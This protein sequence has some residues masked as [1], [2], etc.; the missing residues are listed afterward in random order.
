MRLFRLWTR[1]E[2]VTAIRDLEGA[3]ASGAQSISYTG[4]GT[5][6][7]VTSGDMSRTLMSLYDRLDQLDG[8]K[9]TPKVRH[10]RVNS[11]KG[12]GYHG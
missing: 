1:D 6:A 3:L 12:F 7:Q 8:V 2:I 11:S 9:A 4:G 5:V 10:V